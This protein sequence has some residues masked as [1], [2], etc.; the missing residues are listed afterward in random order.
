MKRNLMT[1]CCTAPFAW[2]RRERTNQYYR[3]A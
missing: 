1:M 3:P 2:K